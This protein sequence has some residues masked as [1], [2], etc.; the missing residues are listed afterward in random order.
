MKTPF[1]ATHLDLL[2]L[3]RLGMRMNLKFTLM[4]NMNSFLIQVYSR[5]LHPCHEE[6]SLVIYRTERNDDFKLKIITR[7]Q[8]HVIVLERK[9]LDFYT[10]FYKRKFLEFHPTDKSYWRRKHPQWLD[11]KHG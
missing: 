3:M 5:H 11:H 4:K 10:F 2:D 1:K 8:K 7:D 9:F 6:G